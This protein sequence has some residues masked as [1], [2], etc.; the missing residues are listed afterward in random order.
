MSLWFLPRGTRR[1]LRQLLGNVPRT[2]VYVV[3]WISEGRLRT[4]LLLNCWQEPYPRRKEVEVFLTQ[5]GQNGERMMRIRAAVPATGEQ[6]VPLEGRGPLTYGICVVEPNTCQQ[7]VQISDGESFAI[8]HGRSSWA[9]TFV[10]QGWRAQ[11]IRRVDRVYTK[12]FN[13]LVREGYG[14]ELFLFNLSDV[15]GRVSATVMGTG[16]RAALGRVSAFGA[17][18]IDPTAPPLGVD[19]SFFSGT[20]RLT[21]TCP[22]DYYVLACHGP[23]GRR[24][25]SLQ[26]VK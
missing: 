8:T 21:A 6:V 12:N 20:M 2:S 22:F 11:V 13:A 17:L 7:H 26:H 9:Y 24:R 10:N 23:T 18:R 19:A 1:T 16:R 4:E 5:Y 15:P 14:L 25:Y 3:P